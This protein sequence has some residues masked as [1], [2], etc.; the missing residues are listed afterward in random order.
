MPTHQPQ[1]GFTE[2]A[3]FFEGVLVHLGGTALDQRPPRD[4]FPGLRQE[5]GFG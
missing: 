4:P 2:K 1:R 3:D 5:R